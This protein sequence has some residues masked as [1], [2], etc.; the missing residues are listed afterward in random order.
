MSKSRSFL[1][2]M[3]QLEQAMPNELVLDN[4]NE[5]TVHD[6]EDDVVS[7][8]YVSFIH[9]YLTDLLMDSLLYGNRRLNYA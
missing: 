1:Y 9:S 5:L 8:E 7:E 6:R 4:T 2:P 3:R